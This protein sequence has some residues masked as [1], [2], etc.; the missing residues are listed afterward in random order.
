[1]LEHP[2]LM[3]LMLP[4]LRADFELVQTFVYMDGPPLECP[5]TALGGVMDALVP[6]EDLEMWGALTCAP[7]ELRMLPGDHF[8][9]H[10]SQREVLRVV[11]DALQGWARA[12]RQL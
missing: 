5:I 4:V 2:E 3:A 12:A 1:V 8:F 9:L 7:F 11:S 10:V 6:R